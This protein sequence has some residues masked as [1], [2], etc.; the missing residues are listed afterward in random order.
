VSSAGAAESMQIESRCPRCSDTMICWYGSRNWSLPSRHD[1]SSRRFGRQVHPGAWA[2][3][4]R[5]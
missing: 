2:V 3:D 5:M 4:A 1:R